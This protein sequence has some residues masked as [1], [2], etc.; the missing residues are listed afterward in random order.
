MAR[1]IEKTVN[2]KSHLNELNGDIKDRFSVK[3]VVISPK[4]PRHVN[5]SFGQRVR[6]S[7]TFEEV[8]GKIVTRAFEESYLL[9]Y[10]HKKFM[11]KDELLDVRKYECFKYYFENH[12]C[13]KA[14]IENHFDSVS[15]SYI[16]DLLSHYGLKD[17]DLNHENNLTFPPSLCALDCSVCVRERLQLRHLQGYSS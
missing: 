9:S 7:G 1:T 17:Q 4:N 16:K 14:W 15:D 3:R 11:A 13:L 12:F 6:Y 2:F 8:K 5:I 10:F